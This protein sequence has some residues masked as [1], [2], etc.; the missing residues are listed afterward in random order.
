M[1]RSHARQWRELRQLY[2]DLR[3]GEIPP[4]KFLEHCAT[5]RDTQGRQRRESRTAW[6]TR[7]IER[8]AALLPLPTARRPGEPDALT[9][10]D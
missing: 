2:R 5:L 3:H 8:E 6:E 7:D 9:G 1:K 4:R 10:R